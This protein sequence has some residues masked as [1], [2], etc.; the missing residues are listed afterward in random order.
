MGILFSLFEESD[1]PT[2]ICPLCNEAVIKNIYIY[3]N[4]MCSQCEKR[5]A[6]YYH[7]ECWRNYMDTFISKKGC[8]ICYR[9]KNSSEL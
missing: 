8:F 1:S 6:S 3:N 9:C 5:C 4:M 2:R 7:P